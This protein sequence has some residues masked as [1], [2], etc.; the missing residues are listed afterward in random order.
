MHHFYQVGVCCTRNG[1]YRKMIRCTFIVVNQYNLL[2]LKETQVKRYGPR[3]RPYTTVYGYCPKTARK[4]CR[5]DR[6]RK[7]RKWTILP[8]TKEII[9]VRRRSKINDISQLLSILLMFVII[10]S[11]NNPRI[12]SSS[13]QKCYSWKSSYFR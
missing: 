4:R 3:I 13:C 8:E 12:L 10:S 9:T 7:S 5:F 2:V 6:L 1:K 11:T